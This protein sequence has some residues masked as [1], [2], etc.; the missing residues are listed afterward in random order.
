MRSASATSSALV[1]DET[2]T[3]MLLV[4][5]IAFVGVRWGRRAALL[6]AAAAAA[7]LVLV[8]VAAGAELSP[9]GYAI[10]IAIYLTVAVLAG[11]LSGH[12]QNPTFETA[13]AAATGPTPEQILT[14]RELEILRMLALGTT[15]AE[16]ARRA[17][18]SENTV[19]THV[20][21]VLHKIDA[22]NRTEAVSW[23]YLHERISPFRGIEKPQ[24]EGET[25]L[26]TVD[27][28]VSGP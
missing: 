11:A 17:F 8:H 18:I 19:K 5:P 12:R 25:G 20:K 7:A 15:N 4:A 14:P 28:R 1:D 13:V 2:G 6:T 21:H 27:E 3:M 9:L 10:R 22:R 23:Y 24:K 16:I 26:H